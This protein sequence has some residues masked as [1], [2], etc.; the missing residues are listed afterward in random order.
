MKKLIALPLIL[1]AIVA[2]VVIVAFTKAN[3]QPYSQ[4][5]EASLVPEYSEVLL[6][7]GH[8]YASTSLPMAGLGGC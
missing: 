1:I 7:F 6:D 2:A 4:D 8:R 5:I 3:S